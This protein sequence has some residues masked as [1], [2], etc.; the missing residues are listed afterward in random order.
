MSI[1]NV[2][3]KKLSP[4]AVTPSYANSGDAGLDL[5]AISERVLYDH[6]VPVLE[7]GFGLSIEIPKGFV[8]LI[9]PRSSITTKT[10]LLLGNSVGVIDSGYRGEIKAL[11]RNALLSG[12]RKYKL[13]EK[14][15]QLI[16][17]QAP[18]IVLEE[19]TEL[20]DTDRGEKGFGSSGK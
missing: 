4:N 7:Y 9:F 19:T 15:A 20:S 13:G 3:F 1:L 5:T 16:I 6:E 2:K 14:V 12:N 8:G 10:T 18:Q 11:F 17:M